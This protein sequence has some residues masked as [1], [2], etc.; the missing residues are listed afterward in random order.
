MLKTFLQK[1]RD[2]KLEGEALWALSRAALNLDEAITFHA[3]RGHGMRG[4]GAALVVQMSF[5]GTSI[6]AGT[7]ES[8]TP[9]SMNTS[10]DIQKP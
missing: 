6:G 7:S 4:G 8:I 2:Q 10:F 9:T 3:R 1:Q 5:A